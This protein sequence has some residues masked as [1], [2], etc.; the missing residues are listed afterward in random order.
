MAGIII[1]QLRERSSTIIGLNF[2][3]YVYKVFLVLD[4]EKQLG[5][6]KDSLGNLRKQIEEAQKQSGEL[7]KAELVHR[8]NIYLSCLLFWEIFDLH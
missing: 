7:I 2:S 3:I 4:V 8:L 6:E 1:Y 5:V